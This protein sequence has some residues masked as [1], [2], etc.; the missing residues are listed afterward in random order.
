MV[1]S[2]SRDNSVMCWD[3]RAK[4]YEPVQTMSEAKD[5]ISAVRLS[6]YEILTASFDTKIRRY[7]IRAGQY[8]EDCIGGIFHSKSI[9]FFIIDGT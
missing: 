9:F 6:G 5:A 3:L 1:V 2:G 4:S 7:D 8:Y